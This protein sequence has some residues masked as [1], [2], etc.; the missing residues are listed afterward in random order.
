MVNGSYFRLDDDDDDDNK[1]TYTYSHN[2]HKRMGKLNLENCLDRRYTLDRMY[3]TR[4][5]I[6][7]ALSFMLGNITSYLS[8]LGQYASRS[9]IFVLLPRHDDVIKWKHF[10]CHWPF[11]RGIHRSPVNSPHKGQ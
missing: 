4:H 1:I 11:V 2:H 10:P 3:P 6:R 8:R 7:H 5:N 9:T